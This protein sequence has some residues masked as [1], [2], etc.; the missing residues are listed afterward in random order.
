MEKILFYLLV[1]PALLTAS[2]SSEFT[3]ALCD[4]RK[5][6]SEQEKNGTALRVFNILHKRCTQGLPED[7]IRAM[8]SFKSI[9][10]YVP[11][12]ADI[13]CEER[14]WLCRRHKNGK[15]RIIPEELNDV[16]S[17]AIPEIVTHVK[18]KITR[19]S[20]LKPEDAKDLIWKEVGRLNKDWHIWNCI[21]VAK[22]AADGV[23]WHYQRTHFPLTVDDVDISIKP[24]AGILDVSGLCLTSLAGIECLPKV[25]TIQH[26]YAGYNFLTTDALRMLPALTQLRK[27]DLTASGFE[28]IKDNFPLLSQLTTLIL[29]GNKVPVVAPGMLKLPALTALD[30]G[31]CGLSSIEQ[32]AFDQCPKLKKLSGLLMA[33]PL[34]ERAKKDAD[35]DVK[36]YYIA[37][38]RALCHVAD[39]VEVS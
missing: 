7:V 13:S 2:E 22:R 30:L 36:E 12:V 37:A 23:T 34:G 14:R 8:P 29:Y 24:N 39:N 5:A 11:L 27:L 6:S 18:K 31:E 1:L 33:N 35:V 4:Y 25:S 17:R 16:T 28:L 10:L 20:E 9:F 38:L 32:G 21:Y 3:L 15:L 26:V 19:G